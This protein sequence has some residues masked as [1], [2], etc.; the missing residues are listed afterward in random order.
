MPLA[1]VLAL[2]VARAAAA[3][4]V[5]YIPPRSIEAFTEQF[6]RSFTSGKVDATTPLLFWRGVDERSRHRVIGLIRRDLDR[7]LGRVAWIAPRPKPRNF[8]S[9]GI[10]MRT[11]LK[12]IGHLIAEFW[13]GDGGRTVS[14]H[15]VGIENGVYYIALAEPVPT[16]AEGRSAA[17]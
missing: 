8:E 12:I 11:N 15:D 1:L 13:G 17:P 14:L 2:G 7:R 5:E 16:L 10:R 4:S 3:E 9:N 6:R